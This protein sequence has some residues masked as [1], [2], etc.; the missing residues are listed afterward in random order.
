MLWRSD[1]IALASQRDT[2]LVGREGREPEREGDRRGG[3]LVIHE[4]ANVKN[5]QK[6]Q[7]TS[8]RQLSPCIVAFALSC[9]R[10][11][12]LNDEATHGNC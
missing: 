1:D 9:S 10:Q 2:L 5:E 7:T 3:F 8:S 6:F 11:R 4:G 12:I